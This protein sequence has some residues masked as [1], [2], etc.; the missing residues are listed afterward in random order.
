MWVLRRH[1]WK[2]CL[3]K[4]QW[5][6]IYAGGNL[7][8]K[9]KGINYFV[10]ITFIGNVF[11]VRG[12]SLLPFILIIVSVSHCSRILHPKLLYYFWNLLKGQWVSGAVITFSS[13]HL[14]ISLPSCSYFKNFSSLCYR[15]KDDRNAAE[16]TVLELCV[17]KAALSFTTVSLSGLWWVLFIN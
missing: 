15:F 7:R 6:V 8:R 13:W 4:V 9:I 5:F 16:L 12:Q 11:D 2:F 1:Q 3:S 14:L 17:I 10:K